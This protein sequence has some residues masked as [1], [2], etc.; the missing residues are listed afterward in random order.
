MDPHIAKN[1][2]RC[3]MKKWKVQEIKHSNER[4]VGKKYIVLTAICLGK[5]KRV[6]NFVNNSKSNLK[7]WPLCLV[8]KIRENMRT[9][10]KKMTRHLILNL[11]CSYLSQ[12]WTKLLLVIFLV[13]KCKYLSIHVNYDNKEIC[14]HFWSKVAK[15]GQ[16]FSTDHDM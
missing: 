3:E 12:I 7:F 14:S 1:I 10:F 4:S 6:S 15:S 11:N 2:E 13:S 5:T 16:N 8:Y 9:R